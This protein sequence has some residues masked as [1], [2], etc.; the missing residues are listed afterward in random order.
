M[1]AL[2]VVHYTFN[3]EYN[4]RLADFFLF[5][6]DKIAGMKP[7]GKKTATYLSVTS[8]AALYLETEN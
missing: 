8:G 1:F 6:E 3:I 2:F 5:F 7:S 4:A